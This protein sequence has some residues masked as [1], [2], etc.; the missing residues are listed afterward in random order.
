MKNFIGNIFIYVISQK[1]ICLIILINWL[2]P[3][4]TEWL[5]FIRSCLYSQYYV[6]GHL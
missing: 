3:T 2:L 4:F 5:P 6:F 1:M